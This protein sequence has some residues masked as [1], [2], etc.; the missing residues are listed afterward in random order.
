M[1]NKS[2]LQLISIL[3][4]YPGEEIIAEADYSFKLE[5]EE[6]AKRINSFLNYLSNNTLEQL[7]QNYVHT[8]DFNEKTNLYLTYSKLKD[9]KERGNILVKLKEIYRDEG[10]EIESEELP[11]YYPL[12]LEFLSVASDETVKHLI[13][14]FKE[15]IEEIN[16]ELRNNNSPYT[17]LIEATLLIFDELLQH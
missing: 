17:E 11:D 3:L 15:S 5:N 2:V 6:V 14:Q 9:E 8:F 12:F 10:F 16:A 4:H 7:T 1:E 13:E